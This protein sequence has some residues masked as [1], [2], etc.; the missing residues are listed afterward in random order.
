MSIPREDRSAWIGE[1]TSPGLRMSARFSGHWQGRHDIEQHGDGP[2][3]LCLDDAVEWGREQATVVWVL[4][5]DVRYSAGEEH[6]DDEAPRWPAEGVTVRSRPSGTPLDGSVQIVPHAFRA[7]VEPQDDLETLAR[8]LVPLM[9]ARAD[10]VE[11]WLTDDDRIELRFS[12]RASSWDAA[13]SAAEAWLEQALKDCS[14]R[15]TSHGT[16]TDVYR[17]DPQT[18]RQL[19]LTSS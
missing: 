3:D 18:L 11:A 15:G 1:D 12:V 2:N 6:P 16:G 8:E 17:G 9:A 7:L 10:G 14:A 19:D 13:L 4:L 5:D